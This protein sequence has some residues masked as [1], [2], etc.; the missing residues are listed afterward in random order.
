VEGF[1]SFL[2]RGAGIVPV[3]LVKVDVVG[4]EPMQ[5]VLDLGHDR[6][7]GQAPAVRAGPHRVAEL[8]GDHDLVPVGEIAQRAAEDLLAG[9]GRVQ[10][11]R[12]EEVDPGLESVL[13]ERAAGLLVQGP[14]RVAAAGVAV[15]HR[16]DG[17]RGHVQAG[18]SQLD[19][20][21][22]APLW[23]RRVLRID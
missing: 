17:D 3:N 13:D 12:V 19:V 22:D 18:G 4:A 8:G 21:H 23:F 16:A 10:V 9:A 5:A 2:E 6:L 14:D 11:G 7:A 1:Q 15:G 20:P